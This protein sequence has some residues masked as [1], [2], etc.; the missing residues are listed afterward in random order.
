MTSYQRIN[1]LTGWLIFLI[2]SA[3]YILTIEPVASFWDC[4]EFIA[5]AY[6][7]QVPHP[8]GAPMFLLIGRM[9]S[10]FASSDVESVGFAVNLVSALSSG[11]TILFLFWSINLIAHKMLKIK[12]GE[13]NT[14]QTVKII[15]AGVIGSLAFTFSDSFWWSAVEAEVYAMS[16]FLTALVVW[17]M[18][19]WDVISDEAE[20]N[21]WLILIGYIIGISIGVHL[22]N[23]VALPALGLIYYF[24]KYEKVT[25]KGVLFTLLI[26]GGILILIW[27]VIILG[28]PALAGQFEIFFINIVGLPFGYGAVI[29]GLLLIGGFVYGI[30][31]AIK[32][33]KATL[34]TFL[35]A[36][37][38][39]LIGYSSYFI[40]PIRSSYDPPIDQNDPEN[41]MTLLS[42][43]NRDQYGS[44]PLLHGQYF[45]AE[46]ISQEKGAPIYTKGEDKYEITDY[47]IETKYDPGRTTILPRMYSGAPGHPEEYRS[48]TGL[49]ANEKPNFVDNIVF[50]VRYQLGHMYFRYLMWNFAGRESDIEGAGWKT[51]FQDSS[52][53]PELMKENKA[54][55]NFWMLPFLLGIAGLF[56][57]Y[58]K[59]L[60]SFSVIGLLFILTGVALILYLNSPATEPRERDYIYAGSYYA[61]AFWIGFGVLAVASLIERAIKNPKMAGAAAGVLCLIVPGIMAAEGWDDHDRSDRYFSVDAARNY[62]ASCAPNAILFTGGDN[63]TFPLW[64]I[65]EVEGYRTDVRVI[66]LSY[67]NTDWYINQ[68][69]QNSYDSEPLPISLSREQVRQ[70]GLNDYLPYVESAGISGAIPVDR[71]L[72]LIRNNNPG[73]QIPTSV[74]KYNMIPSRS[75]SMKV[76]TEKVKSLGIIPE[77]K[78]SLLVDR[79]TWNIKGSGLE[80]KDLMILDIM[81]EN[82]WERPIYFNTTSLNGIKMDLKQY[83]IQEGLAYRLLPLKRNDVNSEF[84]NVEVMYDNLMNEFSFTNTDD[85]DVYYNENYRN[86]FLNHRSVYAAL[87]KVLAENGED[88]KAVKVVDFIREKIS[89]EAVPHDMTALEFIQIYFMTGNEDKANELISEIW[90]QNLELFEY[91]NNNDAP[92]MSRERQISFAVLSQ[93]I[94]ILRAYNMNEKALEYQEQLRT[95]M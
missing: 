68:M 89:E 15:A 84:I 2:A 93:T 11:F 78:A 72:E 41:V 76:D 39:I 88:E 57:H 50:L 66:V 95:L 42:Y 22:L 58:K 29:F 36:F 53:L 65:Q 3:V 21:R 18:L 77:E 44:R 70:G 94:Q 45:D 67:F 26:S 38:F 40:V 13:A 74:G 1:N 87:G 82:N 52:E 55:N 62:L 10:M 23:I 85:P 27:R 47:K 92:Y 5:S 64:F 61:F 14:A 48:W 4:A 35:L 30:M 91:L 7:L 25:F 28:V 34:H 49:R 69:R 80:K 17:A 19:K 6:K 75:L 54:R 71:F 51:M 43:L 33:N 16:S 59:D 56:Y 73:L 60:K 8:A 63:D 81:N 90:A 24:K 32:N 31:Y 79:M 86:F 46:L 9:F 12:V 37:S 20:S 83:V